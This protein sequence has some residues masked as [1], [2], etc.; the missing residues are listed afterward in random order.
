VGKRRGADDRTI[1]AILGHT[2]RRSV[3][4]Y[5]RLADQAVIEVL[6]GAEQARARNRLEKAE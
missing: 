6:G 2:D 3:E 4:R 1:Q 5:A